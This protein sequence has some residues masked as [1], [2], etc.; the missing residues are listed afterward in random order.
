MWCVSDL[1]VVVIVRGQMSL[2]LHSR[3]VL[4]VTCLLNHEIS[5]ARGVHP[6]QLVDNLSP[7]MR[8]RMVCVYHPNHPLI[9]CHSPRKGMSS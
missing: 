7:L 9:A 4:L 1:F 6:R 3:V 2:Q 8:M 5:Q